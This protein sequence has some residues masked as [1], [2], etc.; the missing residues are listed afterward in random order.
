ME[1]GTDALEERLEIGG[2]NPPP[3]K[4]ALEIAAELTTSATA[5]LADR[6]EISDADMA[7]EASDFVEKLRA[8]K[9]GLTAAQKAEL[10]PYDEAIV[11]VKAR[12]RE[13]A[14]Q[15]DTTLASLLTLSEAW[16]KRERARIAAETA[17]REAEARRLREEADRLERERQEAAQRVE[18]EKR[19][20]AA[21]EIDTA[22]DEQ[23]DVG[24]QEAD[25]AADR[26]VE[27]ARTAKAAEQ[28]A[29]KK[30]E[31]AA[32]KGATAKRAMTLTAYWS[33]VVDDETAAIETYKD[34]PTV[35]KAALAAAL[36]VANEA[37]RTLKDESKAPPGFRFIKDERAR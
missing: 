31:V 24:Q 35:R 9:K 29:V 26:A 8:S 34:H 11:G 16:L 20:L 14:S 30:P 15:V 37:A 1:A 12:Y 33:A 18:D 6:P 3:E 36:Q 19:R 22:A 17:A 32:I 25:V 7:K 10:V 4:T 23:Q 2:N 13:P 28:V 5:W 21:A 27:A